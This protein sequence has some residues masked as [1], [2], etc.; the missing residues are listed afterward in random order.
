MPDAA[1]AM[2]MNGNI[3]LAV[4]PQPDTADVFHSPTSYFEYDYLSNTFTRVHA[5]NGGWT[6]NE[7]CYYTNMLDLPDGSILY[8]DQGEPQYYVYQ[9]SGSP[10]AAGIPV[11]NNIVSSNCHNYMV[12]GTGFNG[13][14]EG[15]SFGDDWQMNTNYP[16]VRLTSGTNVYYA[17]SYGW[18]RN[19]VM[20]DSLADTAY[21]TLPASVPHG[22]Y[23]LEVVANGIPS[24][25]VAFY[26]CILSVNEEAEQNNILTVYP[27]PAADKVNIAFE[28]KG[29]SKC[30]ILL[31]D[32]LGRLIS[33]EQTET[34]AGSNVHS[35][36]LNNVAKGIYF[37]KLQ[38]DG[39]ELKSKLIVN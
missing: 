1:G 2:M 33:L 36:P 21:F 38:K 28:S 17:R 37:I 24:N 18:N 35:L 15:A 4:S 29:G 32:V 16:I 5:P 25:P 3:L 39:L 14:S 23:S 6:T 8:G 9:P 7:P 20:T 11:V 19:G 26:P 13:I 30:T 34:I 27:N 10:V 22:S 31:E 12:T